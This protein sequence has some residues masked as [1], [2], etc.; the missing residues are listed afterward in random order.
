M[1]TRPTGRVG[2]DEMQQSDHSA[3]PDPQCSGLAKLI[4]RSGSCANQAAHTS[5]APPN[6]GSWRASERRRVA[7]LIHIHDPALGDPGLQNCH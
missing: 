2:G 4:G 7:R 6:R 5:G 1:C 3:S